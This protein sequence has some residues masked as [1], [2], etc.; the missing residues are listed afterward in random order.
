MVFSTSS[1][2]I[3]WKISEAINLLSYDVGQY[4]QARNCINVIVLLR[5]LPFAFHRLSRVEEQQENQS[6]TLKYN[7]TYIQ[8]SRRI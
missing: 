7:F 2:R 8:S 6:K 4:C 1:Q 3:H 5:L